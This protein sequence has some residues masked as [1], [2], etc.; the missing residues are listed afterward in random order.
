M[1]KITDIGGYDPDATGGSLVKVGTGTL[2][3]SGDNTYTGGTTIGAGTLQLGDGGIAGSIIGN[4]ADN[5]TLA[6][7][8]SDTVIFPGLISGTGGV[9]QVGSGV[10]TLTAINTYGGPT[11]VAAGTLMAGGTGRHLAGPDRGERSRKTRAT[12]DLA[13]FN[14]SIGSLAG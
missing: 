13:G 7:D 12:L 3:L 11:M 9:A 10:T 1:G 5:G 8:R 14:Q 4:V 6:F 2:T